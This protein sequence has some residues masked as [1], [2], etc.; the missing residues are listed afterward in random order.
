MPPDTVGF[1]IP[2]I[3]MKGMR[4]TKLASE[5]PW[6]LRRLPGTDVPGYDCLALRAG[7]LQRPAVLF[8]RKP[9]D[10][11][12]HNQAG[13]GTLVRNAWWQENRRACDQL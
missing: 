6:F 3:F 5:G 2:G 8:P 1:H 9:T 11:P 13:W 10:P 12:G 4:Q 7:R